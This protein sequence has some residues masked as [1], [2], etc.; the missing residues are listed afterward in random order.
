MVIVCPSF[1]VAILVQGIASRVVLWSVGYARP[2]PFH[3]EDF[4]C[5]KEPNSISWFWGELY[6]VSW[7]GQVSGDE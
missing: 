1:L 2:I 5:L 7:I 4:M 3:L 6:C